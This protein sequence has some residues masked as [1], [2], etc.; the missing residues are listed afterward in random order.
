MRQHHSCR[1]FTYVVTFRYIEIMNQHPVIASFNNT[2]NATRMPIRELL[3]FFSK[4]EG[5]LRPLLSI[6]VSGLNR[7]EF[8]NTGLSE[9]NLL[10]QADNPDIMSM[11]LDAYFVLANWSF[12][13]QYKDFSSCNV[14]VFDLEHL[15]VNLDFVGLRRLVPSFRF[16]RC[17]R[18][19]F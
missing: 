4:R 15:A 18:T 5:A 7:N 3:V 11:L 14:A 2:F 16:L 17:R 12:L 8:L 1:H 10:I 9:V 6:N 19:I 13:S